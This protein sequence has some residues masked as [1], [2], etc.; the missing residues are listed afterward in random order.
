MK[1]ILSAIIS[2][3]FTMVAHSQTFID[4]IQLKENM[5]GAAI[6]LNETTVP[7]LKRY[8]KVDTLRC[9]DL[10]KNPFLKDFCVEDFSA[11]ENAPLLSAGGSLLSSIGNLDVTNLADGFAKFL[12]KRTKE[13]LNV[14]FFTKFYEEI[15]KEE[16]KDARTLF[17]QTYLTL[18]AIGN[19]V[20]NYQVYINTLR[21]SFEKDLNSLLDNL[22][23]AINDG[24]YSTFFDQHPDIKATCLSAIYIG[25]S[26]KA[27]VHPGRI[28]TEY[29]ISLLNNVD[30]NIKASVQTLQL[31]SESLRSS[32]TDHYWIKADS[33]K[34]LLNDTVLAKIYFGL[35]YQ[36]AIAENINFTF[37]S[38]HNL[39][40]TAL[41]A[42]AD[43]ME[44]YNAFIEDFIR[45]TSGLT[46]AI[47]NLSG[48]EADKVT[49]ADY[50]NFYN[51]TLNVI[52]YAVK[53]ADLPVIKD[54]INISR[55]AIN[56][57]I[58]LVRTG[59]NIALDISRRNYSSAVLN[60]YTLYNFALETF[61]TNAQTNPGKVKQF[62]LK[63]G[64]F[65]AALSQAENSDEVAA[66][67]EA[68]ALPS[69]SSRVKR[70][71]AFNVSLNAYTGLFIGHEN[72]K[73]IKDDKFFN[74]YGVAA[75]IG[76]AVSTGQK[77]MSYSLFVSLVDLGVVA[78]YRFKDN[79][80]AQVPTIQLKDI[81]SPGAFISVGLPRC[82]VSV[83]LGAQMGPNLR[84]IDNN[85]TSQP[86]LDN[87]YNIYWRYSLSFCVDIPLLNF[88]TK[89]K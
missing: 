81:F 41:I 16:Y 61:G 40:A 35:L 83:N 82:P 86:S 77:H 54:S 27:K 26:L 49:F 63:Y 10:I 21:E 80:T 23:G 55:D 3:S 74:A 46:D 22:P 66:A 36:Q 30:K 51:S 11:S 60:V 71:T 65:A 87:N 15:N 7:V 8:F 44:K 4:A 85:D 37:G 1:K 12:V 75:P 79:T 88:Y 17:P 5:T 52:E 78:A 19:E 67:I 59:G 39:L 24:N 89:S 25:S 73:G 50:Y 57:Y 69:G 53:V 33:V 20:Y 62:L 76:V 38:L 64:S 56:K 68:V 58:S 14:A 29:D 28:I 84:K 31:F 45:Q 32:G 42:S 34:L 18:T 2:I 47:A 6:S 72:I 70:E 9:T 43:N 13:E 48:K